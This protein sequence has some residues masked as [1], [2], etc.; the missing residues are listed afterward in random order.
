MKLCAMRRAC[1]PKITTAAVG[2]CLSRARNCVVDIGSRRV[3]VCVRVRVGIQILSRF[4]IRIRWLH[5][6]IHIHKCTIVCVCV[7]KTSSHMSKSNPIL[8]MKCTLVCA[9]YRGV[10]I[11]V[12]Y[13]MWHILYILYIMYFILYCQTHESSIH[14]DAYT[15]Y[16]RKPRASWIT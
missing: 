15:I 4:C 13:T 12:A 10:R 1:G 3:C 9:C 2:V 6:L 8:A 11:L 5:T 7:C 16:Y 14:T